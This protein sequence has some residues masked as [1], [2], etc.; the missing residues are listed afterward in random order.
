VLAD[1]AVCRVQFIPF[2]LVITRDAPSD[3]TAANKPS[4]GDHATDL[5]VFVTGIA[6]DTQF[7]LPCIIKSPVSVIGVFAYDTDI[8]ILS[9]EPVLAMAANTPSLG[10]HAMPVQLFATGTV[11]EV[12]VVPFELEIAPPSL[13]TAMNKPISDVHVIAVHESAC[14]TVCAV[15]VVPFGL[16]ITPPSLE[17]AA[18][19]PS[20]G[21]HAM[22]FNERAEGSGCAVHVIPLGLVIT[23]FV[24]SPPLAT[25]TNK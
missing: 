25:A 24:V 11:K 1:V 13:A 14:G 17:T 7:S 20:S 18:N 3:E 19:K 21:D 9:I 15:Q 12:H 6:R 16:V 2:E 8:T 4:S 5:H 10:A 23:L 22:A